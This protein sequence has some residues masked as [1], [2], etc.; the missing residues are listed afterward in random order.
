[1]ANSKDAFDPDDYIRTAVTYGR[2]DLVQDWL[3]HHRD[4]PGRVSELVLFPSAM[5]GQLEL[6][7]FGL[8]YGE[9]RVFVVP[10]ACLMDCC[11][12]ATVI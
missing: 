7:S 4:D 11:S 8:E 6:L 9:L 12:T 10:V 1:M 3:P 5:F 2:L